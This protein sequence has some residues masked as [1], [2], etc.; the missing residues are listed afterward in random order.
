MKTK[1]VAVFLD[2][3]GTII[4]DTHYPKDPNEVKWVSHAIEGLRLMREKGYLLFVIS[5]QSGVGRGMISDQQFKSVH[6]R[7][8]QLLKDAQIEIEGFSYCFH[9]PDDQ[10]FCRKPQT[11]LVPKVFNEKPIVWSESFTVGDKLSDLELADNIG[12]TGCLVL[13]G[14]G[15]ETQ[16]ELISSKRDRQYTIFPDLLSMAKSLSVIIESK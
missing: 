6:E 11:G 4:E 2:R 15:Q 8:C 13:S 3:D 5:N 16:I 12:A 7:F 14:K 9:H 1:Q 10:C